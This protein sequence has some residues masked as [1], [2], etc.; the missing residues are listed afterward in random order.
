M[1][2]WLLTSFSGHPNLPCSSVSFTIDLQF[3]QL[4]LHQVP[5]T[6]HIQAYVCFLP[7]NWTPILSRQTVSKRNYYFAIPLTILACA[8]VSFACRK[9]SFPIHIMTQLL[10]N[11]PFPVTTAKLYV[12]VW[13]LNTSSDNQ[14]LKDHP[15]EPLPI[16]RALRVVFHHRPRTLFSHRRSHNRSVMLSLFHQSKRKFKVQ[17]AAFHGSN[18]RLKWFHYLKVWMAYST[19]LCSTHLR[20]DQ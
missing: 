9:F 10:T 2:S 7:L 17:L 16:C 6:P 13:E 4:S 12:P 15:P 3:A 5:H 20:M 19:S 1:R 8:R 18:P 14:V 11:A